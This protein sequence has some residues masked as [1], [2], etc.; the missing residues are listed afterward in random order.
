LSRLFVSY[1]RRDAEPVAL[2]VRELEASG[3]HVWLDRSAIQAGALWQ[4]AIVGGIRCADVFVLVLSRQS[5]ESDN[6]E[7]ELG[8]AYVTGKPIILAA[9]APVPVPSHW[10][11]AVAG[12]EPIIISTGDTEPG[13]QA[14]KRAVTSPAVR[15]GKVDLGR[16][17]RDRLPI[18]LYLSIVA[19]WAVLEDH[20]GRRWWLACALVLA[21]LLWTLR[22]FWIARR[23]RKYGIWLCTTLQGFTSTKR[24]AACRIVSAWSDPHSGARFVF[25]SRT[26]SSA[27]AKFV[28]R[29][30]PVLVDPGNYRRYR[31]D[32]SFLPRAP[33]GALR[34]VGSDRSEADGGTIYVSHAPA[35][36]EAVVLVH[37]MEAAGHV[38]VTAGENAAEA[39]AHARLVLLL[40]SPEAVN[41]ASLRSELHLAASH[42][43]PI[44]VAVLRRTAAPPAIEY[45][46]VGARRVDLSKDFETGSARLL[47]MLAANPMLETVV[48]ERALARCA[49]LCAGL[50]RTTAEF[51]LAMPRM[52]I[53]QLLGVLRLAARLLPSG[54]RRSVQE[55]CDHAAA[56]RVLQLNA[57]G[58]KEH[59]HVLLTEYKHVEAV[60]DGDQVQICTQWRDS[61]SGA[62][63]LFRSGA[64]PS[65]DCSAIDA[66]H[67]PVYVDPANI[68]RYSMD[69]SFLPESASIRAKAEPVPPGSV[70]EQPRPDAVFVSHSEE[71]TANSALL[72]ARLCRV[73]IA[74]A[75]QP[76]GARAVVFILPSSS[77]A[78]DAQAAELRQ[79]HAGNIPIVPVTFGESPIPLAMQL[80]LAGIHRID[81]SH[82]LD[83]GIGD[84][85]AALAVPPPLPPPAPAPPPRRRASRIAIGASVGALAWAS[86]SVLGAAAVDRGPAMPF[87]AGI[88]AAIGLLLGGLLGALFYRPHA[89]IFLLL[90]IGFFPEVIATITL[91]VSMA[92][93][94]AR[95]SVSNSDNI[96]IVLAPACG[97]AAVIGAKLL[98]ARNLNRRLRR[99]GTLLV[100]EYR[101]VGFD[102]SETHNGNRFVRVVT[103]WRDPATG[104]S[105]TFYSR[106]FLRNTVRRVTSTSIPV[107]VDTTNPEDYFMD[108]SPARR[109]AVDSGR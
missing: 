4:E 103:E 20:P 98:H 27:L 91:A 87:I 59:G 96:A 73:G 23:L 53:L 1:S 56:S 86:G 33:R 88:A 21:L 93:L 17:W 80:P 67:I 29:E 48:A 32:L 38:V 9:L 51:L 36:P 11:Y 41:C 90:L 26:I 30:L 77:A 57:P 12:V 37:R 40:L 100:T 52:V 83:A 7:K 64:I 106:N 16:T 71:D 69:L 97:L 46:L 63:Y 24:Q 108:L 81:L 89:K 39:I 34:F 75:S 25:S 50:A 22:R 74:I 76:C 2:L 28:D 66:T 19:A 85:L 47:E 95:I 44:L 49:G 35:D 43:R 15:S 5:V 42:S 6:V 101:G 79:A 60:G 54:A 45:A 18:Y 109:K 65:A 61:V 62:L 58:W 94:P 31:M 84:L 78:S 107:Y 92:L 3:H 13:I 99:T 8:F 82:D 72:S 104:E 10:R 14:L 55:W 70:R 102:M 105:R 68:R